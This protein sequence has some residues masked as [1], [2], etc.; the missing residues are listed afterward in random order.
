MHEM[1]IAAALLDTIEAHRVEHGAVRVL[2]VNLVVGER[3]GI[4]DD[5]LR[6]AFELLTEG[7]PVE[8][9][10]LTLRR[11]ALRFHCDGCQRDYEPAVFAFDCPGCGAVGRL[12]DDGSALLLESLEIET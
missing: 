7:T 6:F 2:A 9:A 8:G 1:S 4:V 10:T 5:S 11:T 3:A 12:V